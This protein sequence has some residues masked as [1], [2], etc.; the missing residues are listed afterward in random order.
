MKFYIQCLLVNFQIKSLGIST[1]RNSLILWNKLVSFYC[2][3]NKLLVF[4]LKIEKQGRNILILFCG[5]IREQKT[6]AMN[7]IEIFI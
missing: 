5:M 6:C 2:H 3:F 4:N 1:Q 7:L